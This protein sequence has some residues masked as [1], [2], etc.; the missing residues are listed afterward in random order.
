MEILLRRAASLERATA[1]NW[2]RTVVKHEAM[3]VR[4]ARQA[5]VSAVDPGLDEHEAV[6]LPSADERAARLDRLGHAAEALQRLKPQEVR[7]LLLKA[8]GHSYEEICSITGWTY[9]KV[10]RC[11]TEGRRAFRARYA[12]IESG[13]EC[14]RWAPLL[15]T[16]AD[17]EADADDVLA[18]RP[19]LRACPSCRA[20]LRDYRLAAREVAALVPVAALAGAGAAG[21]EPSGALSAVVARVHEAVVGVGPQ[22]VQAALDAAWSGKVAAIAASTV[23]LAG[24]GVVVEREVSRLSRPRPAVPREARVLARHRAPAARIV[25]GAA[26]AP[27]PRS[28]LGAPA[29]VVGHPVPRLARPSAKTRTPGPPRNGASSS[30]ARPSSAAGEFAPE[31]PAP[32][33]RASSSPAPSP[34]STSARTASAARPASASSRSSSGGGGNGAE[35]GF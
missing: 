16:I 24:G 13:E 15:S 17:G 5:S 35:F 20:A 14:E 33:S 2:M 4:A 29:G 6:A 26:A 8:E 32:V 7:A 19:H 1:L 31:G 30:S 10:N 25:A 9:T 11:L 22:K 27:Q 23:A 12:T 28:S 21:A 3:A 34:G 18:A